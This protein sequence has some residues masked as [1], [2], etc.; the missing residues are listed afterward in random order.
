MTETFEHVVEPLRQLLKLDGADLEFKEER[1]GTAYFQLVLRD[2]NCEECVMPREVL[3]KITLERF[4][5]A[6]PSVSAVKID[7]PR[8]SA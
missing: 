8:R 3:E 5:E 6:L 1:D 7:D 2:A 4:Q